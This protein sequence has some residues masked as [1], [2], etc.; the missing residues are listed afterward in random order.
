MD[1]V[2]FELALIEQVMY[3]QLA[4]DLRPA[5]QPYFYY[6]WHEAVKDVSRQFVS[7]FLLKSITR[8]KTWNDLLQELEQKGW[9]TFQDIQCVTQIHNDVTSWVLQLEPRAV[10]GNLEAAVTYSHLCIQV[11][12]L[13]CEADHP[14]GHSQGDQYQSI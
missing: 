9:S 12:A 10:E 8:F 3:L 11:H 2:L 7:D 14:T 5:S 6:A 4:R 1:D 13:D